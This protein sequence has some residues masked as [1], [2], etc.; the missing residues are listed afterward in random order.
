MPVELLSYFGLGCLVGLLSGLFGIGGGTVLVPFLIWQFDRLGF[1]AAI[2]MLMA[3]ATSLA[4]IVITATVSMYSHSRRGAVHWP[5]VARMVPGIVLGSV[6]GS[7]IAE[8]LPAELFQCLFAL[9]LLYVA[10]LLVRSG[11]PGGR[12]P[13]LG[14]AK[15]RL[16]AVGI[17]TASAIV[18]IGG[19]SLTVP[20]LERGGFCIREAVGVS[21]ALGVP[22]A[23]AGT[24]GYVL[25]GWNYRGLPEYTLGYV[26]LPAVAAIVTGSVPFA[27]VGVALVHRL[28]TTRLKQWFALVLIA[29]GVKLVWPVLLPLLRE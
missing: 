29:T 1:P 15:L 5:T 6:A 23:V 7:V 16:A 2:Q 3:V 9:F 12:A 13:H 14:K 20:F 28:P 4:T 11:G 17:G 26:H 10:W 18:G 22:I 25:L 24:L 8:C 21:S 27:P 19:G